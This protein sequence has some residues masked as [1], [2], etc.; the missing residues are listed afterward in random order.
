[1]SLLNLILGA[2]SAIAEAASALLRTLDRRAAERAGRD[3][4]AL[5]DTA[6]ALER[7]KDRVQ[8]DDSLRDAGPDAL[9]DELRGKPDAHP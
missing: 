6:R 7:E 1:M 5:A 4:A 9:A 8:I 2:V 3:Q